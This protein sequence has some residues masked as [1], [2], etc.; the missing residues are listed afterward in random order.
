M[1]GSRSN[2]RGGELHHSHVYT[3]LERK[4]GYIAPPVK[5]QGMHLAQGHP[6]SS[7]SSSTATNPT[8]IVTSRLPLPSAAQHVTSLPLASCKGRRH[9]GSQ[10]H[11]DP[12]LGRKERRED[13]SLR[14]RPIRGIHLNLTST[15]RSSRA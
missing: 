4:R 10:D 8:T 5:G 12:L 7:P 15:P 1:K 6:S 9:A 11:S 3:W 13:S 2:S 14:T